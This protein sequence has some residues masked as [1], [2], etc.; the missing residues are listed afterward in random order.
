MPVDPDEK[1]YRIYRRILRILLV[2]VRLL[3]VAKDSSSE[4]LGLRQ[5]H[6]IAEGVTVDCPW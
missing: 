4:L 5:P 3:F 1:R 6:G 2:Q